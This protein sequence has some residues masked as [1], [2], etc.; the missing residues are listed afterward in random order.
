MQRISPPTILGLALC[1]LSAS[2]LGAQVAGKKQPAKKPAND[3][4]TAQASAL[5]AELAKYNDTAPEA[6]DVL[7][8]LTALYHKHGRVFG[9]LRAGQRFV[10]AHPSDKRH[11]AVMLQLID[12]LEISSRNKELTALCRQFLTRYPKAPQCPDIEIRLAATLHQLN[13]RIAAADADTAVFHRQPATLVGQQHACA[14][15]SGV[16]RDQ[17]QSHLH[18]GCGAG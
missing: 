8:K 16:W 17:Q 15:D 12:G 6:A 18:Q 10:T 4:V 5:E 13:D 14:R 9:L 1:V 7:V 2:F 3:G 11:P